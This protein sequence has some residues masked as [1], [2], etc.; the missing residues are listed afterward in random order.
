MH[1]PSRKLPAF[2]EY[3]N[4]LLADYGSRSRVL[5]LASR[6]DT[7]EQIRLPC[8]DGFTNQTPHKQNNFHISLQKTFFLY[9][10]FL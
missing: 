7:L 10:A 8:R 3:P 6:D 9:T 2:H 1:D 5:S 4:L